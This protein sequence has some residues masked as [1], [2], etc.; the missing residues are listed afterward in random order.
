[1]IRLLKLS[2][3]KDEILSSED[4]LSIYLGYFLTHGKVAYSTAIP[5]AEKPDFVLLTLGNDESVCYLCEVE[6][7]AYMDNIK[8][9][10]FLE[11]T[12]DI[13]KEQEKKTWLMFNSMQ[14]ISIDFLDE[15]LSDNIIKEFIKNRSNNK[16]L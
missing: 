6:D 9:Q 3:N 4:I 10:T 5:V 13:Y 7:H 16:T 8:A 15:L 2:E 11:Y 12:P 1:M 14:K